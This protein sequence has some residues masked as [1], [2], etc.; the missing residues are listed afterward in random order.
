[1]VIHISGSPLF[2]VD[3]DVGDPP[4]SAAVA[5]SGELDAVADG[6]VSYRI[7][8]S[9]A[10]DDGR[11]I[12]MADIAM[13]YTAMAYIVVASDNGRYIVMAYI[14]MA[15]IVMAYIVVA[16][17]DGRFNGAE[18]FAALTNLDVPMPIIVDMHPTLTPYIATQVTY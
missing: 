1:M 3:F 14:A 7:R 18:A 11:Y 5:I 10:S 9:C 4:T 12:V 13:A 17:N 15:Y 16:S 6:D 2:D 8:A